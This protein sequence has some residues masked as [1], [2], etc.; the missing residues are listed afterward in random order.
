MTGYECDQCATTIRPQVSAMEPWD[1]DESYNIEWRSAPDDDRTRK[2]ENKYG[3][4]AF[5]NVGTWRFCSLDCLRKFVNGLE[6][7]WP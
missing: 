3:K 5:P 2:M 4:Q 6:E 1:W 7:D